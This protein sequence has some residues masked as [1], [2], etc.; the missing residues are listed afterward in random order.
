MTV[1][2][3]FKKQVDSKEKPEA[4]WWG[5]CCCGNQAVARPNTAK[6]EFQETVME[7]PNMGKVRFA[8]RRV[9]S[10]HHKSVHVFRSCILECDNCR[11]N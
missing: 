1:L 6:E 5:V 3:A 8:C 2:G 9:K 7:V 4:Y 10:K 11:E